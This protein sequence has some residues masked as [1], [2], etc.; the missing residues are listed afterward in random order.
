[1]TDQLTVPADIV[2]SELLVL[3]WNDHF[4]GKDYLNPVIVENP[5]GADIHLSWTQDR[6]AL[7]QADA[8]WFHGPTITDMPALAEKQQPWVLMSME[9]DINYPAL[10]IPYARFAFDHHMTYR[11][12][13][14]IPCIY[15]NWLRYGSFLQP[16]SARQNKSAL[17]PAVYIASNPVQQRDDYITELMQHIRVDCLGKCLNNRQIDGG[18]WARGGWEGI[19]D[20]L[21]HYKF[22]LAFENSSTTDYVTE[23]V[24]HA[25]MCGTVPVYLGADNVRDFMPDDKAV[26]VA[27]DFASPLQLA[28]YLQHLDSHDAD[29]QTHLRWKQ[30][31]YSPEFKTLVDLG[32]REPKQRLAIKLAHGCGQ[33]CRCGGRM[34]EAGGDTA[35]AHS[36]TGGKSA[37]T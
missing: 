20:V 15:P 26:I 32:S 28:T 21:P 5:N 2:K 23:K 12:D 30:D 4:F 9:S 17:A 3:A 10:K 35:P 27:A 24:F 37:P 18:G 13:S 14:D 34:K 33:A 6:S 1:M 29:Y 22:Y 11:L 25:L 36:S 8:V 19:T 16:P 7:S 31:G